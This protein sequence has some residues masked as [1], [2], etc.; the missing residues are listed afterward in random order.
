M[1]NFRKSVPK[2]APGSGAPKPKNGIVKLVYA[3]DI[4][5][6]PPSDA[7]GVKMEGNIVLKPG[8]K[9]QTLYLTDDTQKLSHSTEGDADAEGFLKKAEASHPGDSLE[10]N[11]FAQNTI[12]EGLILF[13]DTECNG[14][15]YKVLGTPCNPMYLKGELT[16]DKDG[17]KH[18]FNF[19][20]RR[21]DRYVAKFYDG[22]LPVSDNYAPA[23]FA[24]ALT[25][26][27]GV[28]VQLPPSEDEES[29]LSFTALTMTN[30][31]AVITLI[32]GGGAEPLTIET[33]TIIPTV[34]IPN[35]ILKNATPW[36]ALKDAIIQ[37]KYIET[38]GGTFY[39]VEL[40]RS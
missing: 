34:N 35:Y 38:F 32:G 17:V 29:E 25:D 8:A 40:S 15:S 12:G 9:V 23:T 36:V 2:P 6:F 4:T 30:R 21:R 22:A 7:N 16:D 31:N 27:N 14:T 10:I 13:V 33:T 24:L 11:E 5:T 1:S 3:A 37:F 26:A 18:M 28:I 19:E 20:Q 39:L